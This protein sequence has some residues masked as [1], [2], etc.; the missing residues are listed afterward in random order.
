MGSGPLPGGEDM[1][2]LEFEGKLPPISLLG[3]DLVPAR[4][5]TVDWGRWES[6]PTT[7]DPGPAVHKKGWQLG[8]LS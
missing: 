4:L 3:K 7:S 6:P 8:G 5:M 2:G 1:G